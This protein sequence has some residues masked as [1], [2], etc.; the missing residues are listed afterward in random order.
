MSDEGLELIAILE[1]DFNPNQP[2]LFHDN[3]G[4]S[5]PRR[6]Y[7]YSFPACSAV[8]RETLI[9]IQLNIRRFFSCGKKA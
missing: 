6:V 9:E 7:C 5:Y 1:V 8:D 4:A 2:D 3:L